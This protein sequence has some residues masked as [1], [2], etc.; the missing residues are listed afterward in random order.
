VDPHLREIHRRVRRRDRTGANV[1]LGFVAC[2]PRA[3]RR[4]RSRRR[5]LRFRRPRHLI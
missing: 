2:V 3:S 4:R 5:R 1:C